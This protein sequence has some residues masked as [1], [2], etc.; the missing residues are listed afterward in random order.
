MPAAF[1]IVV[2]L[3]ALCDRVVGALLSSVVLLEPKTHLKSGSTPNMD[4]DGQILAKVGIQVWPCG[5]PRPTTVRSPPGRIAVPRLAQ[6]DTQ[7][8]RA[9]LG[10]CGFEF[11]ARR[12]RRRHG[13]RLRVAISAQALLMAALPQAGASQVHAHRPR[14]SKDQ[15]TGRPAYGQSAGAADRDEWLVGRATGAL[16][17]FPDER[18]ERIPP[19]H[20]PQRPPGTRRRR[21]PRKSRRR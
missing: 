1:N 15:R 4:G 20:T 5:S 13:P 2:A 10:T 12:V 18:K 3:I 16:Q 14:N 6:V 8:G 9:P 19:E 21:R 17:R 7:H 11:A